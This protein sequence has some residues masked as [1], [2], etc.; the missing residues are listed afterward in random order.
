M[1]CGATKAVTLFGPVRMARPSSFIL[2]PSV[3]A[4]AMSAGVM[5]VMP[6]VVMAEGGTF[7]PKQR[8]ARMHIF[9]PAS[10]P[11]TSAVGSASA[12]PF[13]CASR[14]ACSKL[15]PRCIISV[16]I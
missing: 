4:Q 9:L 5:C 13:S 6:S 7:L 15:L 12:K 10:M 11:S 2:Y 3:L 14:R 16:S 8:S 1:R